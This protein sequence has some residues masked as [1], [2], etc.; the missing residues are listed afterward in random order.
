MK[1][2]IIFCLLVIVM[3]MITGCN[4]KKIDREINS[5]KNDDKYYSEVNNAMKVI[6]NGNEYIVNLE[7]NNTVSGL[8]NLLP[9]EI[10]MNEL[11]GNEKYF[12]LDDILPTNSYKPGHIEAGDIML[13]GND[14]LVIF[15]KSF[16]T[17]YSYTKIGHVNNLPDLGNNNV[18]V[19]FEMEKE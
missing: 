12:Y 8:I 13:Y 9:L 14:C 3:F 15:Y 5:T 10:N 7:D 4:S 6:I 16:D 2:K 19:K 11:N 1:K 17:P 18:L